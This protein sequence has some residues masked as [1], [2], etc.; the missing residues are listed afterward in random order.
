MEARHGSLL[1]A[2]LSSRRERR[3]PPPRRGRLTTFREGLD[4][5]T[6]A[7]A[8]SLDTRLHTSQGVQRLRMAAGGAGYVLTLADGRAV[9]ADAVVLAG[10][11][12]AS[13]RLLADFDSSLASALAEIPSAPIATVGLGYEIAAIGRRL[14]GFGFLAPR[15]SGLRL[16]GVLWESSIFADR[17]PA[18]R[19]LLRVMVGGATDAD[20]VDLDDERLLARV[21]AELRTTMQVNGEPSFV[22]VVRHRVGIPQYVIGHTERMARIDAALA[23][24]PGLFVGGHAFRGV[25]VNACIADA[26]PLAD[27]VIASLAGRAA[28]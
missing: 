3:E 8:R 9:S 12:D 24:H 20:A 18:G 1:K 25:G 7:L 19:A 21:R 17:A 26:G 4:E 6:G 28:A 14:D 10:G 22:R 27:R 13:A 2:M 15:Q 23:G 5:L 11:A 16:L